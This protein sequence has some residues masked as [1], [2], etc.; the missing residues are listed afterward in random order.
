MGQQ[1]TGASAKQNLSDLLSDAEDKLSSSTSSSSS[2]TS[3]SSQVLMNSLNALLTDRPPRLLSKHSPSSRPPFQKRSRMWS[4][5]LSASIYRQRSAK[6]RPRKQGG[7]QTASSV[8]GQTAPASATTTA[9]ITESQTMTASVD[10]LTVPATA[11]T[12]ATAPKTDSQ[13]VSAAATTV[14]APAAIALDGL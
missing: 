13:T 4:K 12:T 2:Q 9:P 6:L 1:S 10:S 14:A 7:N 11:S 5:G 3:S 8:D